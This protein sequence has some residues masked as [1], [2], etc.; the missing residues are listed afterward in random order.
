MW[1]ETPIVITFNREERINRKG[2]RD[3]KAQD[4][5]VRISDS[6]LSLKTCE[7]HHRRASMHDLKATIDPGL[8]HFSWG[9]SE[10]EL[11]LLTT[12]I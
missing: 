3:L 10:E 11:N 2:D 1:T 5:G 6:V 8:C 12:C 4:F 9:F 7:G